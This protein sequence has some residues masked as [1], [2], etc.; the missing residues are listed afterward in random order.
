MRFRSEPL[1]RV[2][3]MEIPW[4]SNA[5]GAFSDQIDPDII[6]TILQVQ[7]VPNTDANQPSNN[8]SIT[9]TDKVGYDLL[10]GQGA[11]LSNATITRV[12]PVIPATDG[13]NTGSGPLVVAETLTINVTN[14]GNA[15]QGKLVLYFR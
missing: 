15:K 10:R 4:T 5:S 12:I 9:L 13:T 7:F 6:G 8:Y 2:N 14:A 11:S 3:R 1:G